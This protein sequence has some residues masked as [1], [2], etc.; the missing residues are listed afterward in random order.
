MTDRRGGPRALAATLSGIAR[1][2]LGRRG[3]AEGGLALDWPAVAGP[4]LAPHCLPLRIAF[5]PGERRLGT[6]HLRVESGFAPRLAH[7]ESM[8]VERVNAH[9]GYA[10]V[11]RIKLLQGPLP[12][13]GK[14][15]AAS[16]PA[17]PQQAD[18][19]D[20]G[21]DPTL[22]S[23]VGDAD[24]AAALADFAKALQGRRR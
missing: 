17:A 4:D 1:R 6:L 9:L 19:G 3:L 21:C 12:N 2:A 7:S 16:V 8:L 11:A 10:A 13:P 20:S 24:L 15:A 5:P 22:S 14:R 18:R 23:A